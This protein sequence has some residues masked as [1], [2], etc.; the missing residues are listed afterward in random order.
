MMAGIGGDLF[1]IIYEAATGKVHGLNASGWAPKGLNPHF[2]VSQGIFRMPGTG[3]H[4]ATV[5]GTIAGWDAM[6]SR[7]GKKTFADVFAP[8]IMSARDGFPVTEI[9]GDGWQYTAGYLRTNAEAAR[10]FLINGR[11]PK[12]GELFRNPDLAWSLEEIARG[13][14]DAFYKGS[15][16]QK[17]LQTSEKLGGTMAADDLAEYAP[18]WVDPIS[19]KYRG[20][21]VY[22]MP[23]NEQGIAA[24]MMLNLMEKFPLGEWGHNSVRALHAMIEAK[25]LAYADMITYVADPRFA[26]VPVA[27]M[28]SADYA[29]ERGALI[30]QAKANC[31]VGPGQPPYSG[32]DTTYL[33]T[34]DRDGNM[35]S[36]IQSNFG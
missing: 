5:P 31:S 12:V 28:L 27:G 23:P 17:I 15:I 16:A 10:V 3:I 25:K 35:V 11:A 24:L 20:W 2:L 34:V 33:S 26:K 29:R 18:E 7:F 8:T 4:S 21:T 30:D 9:F 13:G 32:S 22:E 19:T 6:L 1:V 14:K 36:L